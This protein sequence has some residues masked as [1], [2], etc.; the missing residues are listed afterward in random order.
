MEKDYLNQIISKLNEGMN[1][2]QNLQIQPTEY[3]VT[4]I[5]KVIRAMREAG[6]IAA[7]MNKLIP[8]VTD[9]PDAAAADPAEDR[10]EN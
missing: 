8:V 7:E 2:V 3:N 4:M 1:A 10:D 5:L 6:T 9:A